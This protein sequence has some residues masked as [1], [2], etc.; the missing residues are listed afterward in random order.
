MS[1]RCISM[2]FTGLRAVHDALTLTT[3]WGQAYL[4]MPTYEFSFLTGSW[5]LDIGIIMMGT[6]QKLYYHAVRSKSN[7]VEWMQRKIAIFFPNSIAR[8]LKVHPWWPTTINACF[9]HW[10][11]CHRIGANVSWVIWQALT[12][13]LYD[14]M[15]L[16][17]VE[18][19]NTHGNDRSYEEK[20]H[21]HPFF[22]KIET[23]QMSWSQ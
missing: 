21:R 2:H 18:L 16:P 12:V 1:Q 13:S 10:L 8:V 15:E 19:A 7:D 9:G 23:L 22:S 14:A 6:E 17:R 11:V 5:L 4:T 3:K 20:L